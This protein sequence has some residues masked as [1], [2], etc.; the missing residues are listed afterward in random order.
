M[1]TAT[2]YI[3]RTFTDISFLIE[4]R[5]ELAILLSA[6]SKT[7]R[8]REPIRIQWNDNTN[9]KDA[10]TFSDD[11][12]KI[13]TEHATWRNWSY[14][15]LSTYPISNGISFFQLKVTSFPK[16]TGRRGIVVG[17]GNDFYNSYINVSQ[18]WIEQ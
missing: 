9:R 1:S 6:L 14:D 12:T 8:A 17:V 15:A 5:A 16:E 2:C 13:S 18:T 7:F 11:R 10:F 3:T 4:C